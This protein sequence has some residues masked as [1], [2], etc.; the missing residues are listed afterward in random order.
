ML[1]GLFDRAVLIWTL[2]MHKSMKL[3]AIGEVV[4]GVEHYEQC[5]R[6]VLL[7]IVESVPGYAQFGSRAIDY[8][9][10]PNSNRITSAI[11]LAIVANIPQI[12]LISTQYKNDGNLK[13]TVEV[14]WQV[15]QTQ[16]QY[17]TV[18]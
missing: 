4:T 7:T 11:A 16:E 15:K 3:G 18:I 14:K 9:D 13:G 8:L 5:L 10:T 17:S 6:L 1:I 12:K 2:A